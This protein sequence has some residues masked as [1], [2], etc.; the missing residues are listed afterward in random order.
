MINHKIAINFKGISNDKISELYESN[1]KNNPEFTPHR[2]NKYNNKYNIILEFDYWFI[3]YNDIDNTI[4]GECSVIQ[5]NYNVFEINDVYVSQK[6]RGNNYSILLIMNVLHY[7]DTEYF[8]INKLT[9]KLC[10]NID[11]IAAITCYKKIF[12]EPYRIDSK[13]TYFAI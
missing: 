9:V 8:Y 2:Y 5:E 13:Y 11:N 3:L 4:I 10:T 12:G 1:Y 7:F 6:Y